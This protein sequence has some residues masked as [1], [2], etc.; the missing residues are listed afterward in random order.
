MAGQP[1]PREVRLHVP[2]GVRDEVRS[3]RING[4]EHS[5]SPVMKLCGQGH[6]LP[7]SA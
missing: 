3:I 6:A 1:K 4:T 7:C 2:L 5:V